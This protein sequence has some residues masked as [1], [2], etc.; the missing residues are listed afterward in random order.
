M[1]NFE[2]Q[3]NTIKPTYKAKLRLTIKILNVNTQKIDGLLLKNFIIVITQFLLKYR[4]RE[5]RIF[6]LVFL[7]ANT[8]IKI[9]LKCFF[10]YSIIQIY[11]FI[12]EN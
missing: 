12:L 1:I 9:G 10:S 2:I 7:L 3:V 5:I 6:E 11:S 4:L 8:D